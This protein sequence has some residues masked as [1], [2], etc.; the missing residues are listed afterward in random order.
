MFGVQFA[1]SAG[2]CTRGTY[3]QLLKLDDKLST[4]TNC[5][6]VLVIDTEGLR[7][8]ELSDQDTQQHDNELATLVIGLASVTIINIFGEV[9]ADIDDILQTTVHAFIRMKKVSLNQVVSL[10]NIMLLM[11]LPAKQ[12]KADND[13]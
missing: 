8:P 12:M 10:L 9:S 1:V 7:A 13:S 3:F 2:R 4:E 11:F 5:D 6:Y